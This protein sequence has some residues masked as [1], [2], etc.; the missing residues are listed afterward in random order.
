MPIEAAN[1]LDGALKK[2]RTVQAILLLTIPLYVYAGEIFRL[3]GTRD[4]KKIGLLLV[5]L[6]VLNVWSV[7]APVRHESSH[8][9][10]SG[11]HYLTG[12]L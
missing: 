6:A 1:D 12:S 5:V 2:T 11:Q 7:L 4:V 8:P 9:M 3:P 10:D